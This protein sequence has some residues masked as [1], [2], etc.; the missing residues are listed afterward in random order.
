MMERYLAHHGI[1][2]QR[3]GRRNGPPYPLDSKSHSVSEKKAN[4]RKSL[5]KADNK[6][7]TKNSEHGEKEKRHLTDGQ[8]R[9]IKIGAAAVVTA[10]AAYGTYKLAKSGKL[11]KLADIGKE[12][13]NAL[14]GKKGAEVKAKGFLAGD[15]DDIFRQT[16]PSSKAT[17]GFKKLSRPEPVA[18]VIKHTN[19]LLGKPEGKN[20]C[21]ACGIASFIRHFHGL[22]VVAK[23][24]G[25]EMQNLGG[26]VEE[27]FKGAKVFDGS[28][29]K[30][31]RSRKDAAEMLVRRFGDNAEGVVSVQFR[32]TG[33]GHIFN[34]MINAG[35]VS[36]FDGQQ[37]WDDAKVSRIY[38]QAIDPMG[39]L[40]LARLD[41]L[42]VN[43]DAIKK[44]AE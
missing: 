37:G 40:Q 33:G 43:W 19:P 21:S 10:L 13:L 39:A 28:A 8:K 5:D 14:L 24:T 23:S 9:A 27:C 20:N 36:F 2:G 18:E 4:W 31:G 26:V 22:D 11:D 44:Y 38:W 3:W 30:F 42:D 32:G 6:S 35:N 41:G 7:Y 15:A 1:L 12:K 25:G 16:K 34:W 17:G 29:V